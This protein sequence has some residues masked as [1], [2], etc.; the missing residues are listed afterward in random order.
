[1]VDGSIVCAWLLGHDFVEFLIW[2]FWKKSVPNCLFEAWAQSIECYLVQMLCCL[3]K[4]TLV[5]ELIGDQ[6][7]V[8]MTS[9]IALNNV[10]INDGYKWL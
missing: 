1:M 3:Y 6:I 9:L 5:C 7:R 2:Q 4:K 10:G 8:I